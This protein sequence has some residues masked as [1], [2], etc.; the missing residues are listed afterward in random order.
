MSLIEATVSL[1]DLQYQQPY[2][3]WFP[4]QKTP[5]KNGGKDGSSGRKS[6]VFFVVKMCFQEMLYG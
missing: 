2:R 1:M 3:F 6:P 5:K 4:G